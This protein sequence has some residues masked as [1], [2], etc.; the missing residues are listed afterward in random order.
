MFY[1][2]FVNTFKNRRSNNY[3]RLNY[4]RNSEGKFRS[5][6]VSNYLRFVP[7]VFL[8]FNFWPIL[9][10]NVGLRMAGKLKTTKT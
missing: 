6:Y 8:N 5:S 2:F 3:N 4:V 9:S 1:I 7:E 10:P